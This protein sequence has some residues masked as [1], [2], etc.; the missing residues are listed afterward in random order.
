MELW[1]FSPSVL[2]E[3]RWSGEVKMEAPGSIAVDHCWVEP[4]AHESDGV[5]ERVRSVMGGW[6]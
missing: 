5:G 1:V 3:K 2:T 6:A 4:D